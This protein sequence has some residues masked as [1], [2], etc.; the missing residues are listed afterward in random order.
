MRFRIEDGNAASGCKR[1]VRWRIGCTSLFHDARH[2][3]ILHY[4]LPSHEGGRD[5]HY[6]K[7]SQVLNRNLLCLNFA[8][9]GV[10]L[11]DA[12]V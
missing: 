10:P 4:D 9:A 7:K 8:K 11:T 1:Y 2:A 3:R 12:E 5:I 6:S